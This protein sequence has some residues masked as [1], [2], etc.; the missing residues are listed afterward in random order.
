A[1]RPAG[2]RERAH[3]QPGCGAAARALL[4][5]DIARVTARRQ[6]PATGRRVAARAGVARAR[7]DRAAASR[8]GGSWGRSEGAPPGEDPAL[9]RLP[10]GRDWLER[11][12]ARDRARVE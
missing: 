4:S 6:R 11:L 2:G 9:A 10:A 5:S 8:R 7:A 3:A 12:H 1:A